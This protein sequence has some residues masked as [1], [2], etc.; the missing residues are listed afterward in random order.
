MSI[1]ITLEKV[2]ILIIG[3][4]LGALSIYLFLYIKQTVSEKKIKE[5][6]DE[7]KRQEKEIIISAE[8]KAIEILE[9]AR[10][11]REKIISDL[12]KKY[13]IIKRKNF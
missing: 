8:K 2:V 7:L 11:E 3:F 1:Y 9:K 10:E 6:I 13:L 4:L 12:Q 5:R